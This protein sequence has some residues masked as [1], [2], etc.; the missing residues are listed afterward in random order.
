[1]LIYFR[2]AGYVFERWLERHFRIS[3]V[4]AYRTRR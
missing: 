2:S 3:V 4:E 1:M